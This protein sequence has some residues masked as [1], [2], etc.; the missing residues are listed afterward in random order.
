VEKARDDDPAA[1]F[2]VRL[3]Q[4]EVKEQFITLPD[5]VKNFGSK[6]IGSGM[7]V[8]PCYAALLAVMDGYEK[9]KQRDAFQVEGNPGIGKTNFAMYAARHFSKAGSDVIFESVHKSELFL[10]KP[11]GTVYRGSRQSFRETFNDSRVTYIVDGVAPYLEA[12][13]RVI[14]VTTPK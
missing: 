9:K 8:R 7:F 10:L 12:E 13:G 11:D 14:L 6:N 4:A 5:G 2:W 3:L 1:V